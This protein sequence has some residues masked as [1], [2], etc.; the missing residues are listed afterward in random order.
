MIRLRMVSR[1][2]ANVCL[3]RIFFAYVFLLFA[4]GFVSCVTLAEETDVVIV[5]DTE[6]NID[7][8]RAKG[9]LVAI[10]MDS[11]FELIIQ[12]TGRGIPQDVLS[13]I[14]E[15]FYVSGEIKTGLGL[16]YIRQIIEEH[17]GEIRISSGH[18]EGTTV[19][20]LLPTHI[21]ELLED[22]AGR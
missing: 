13:H 20:I 8:H 1:F 3:P 18:P 4:S 17:R 21:A 14:F 9:D 12:D 7:I 11:C 22:R 10:C 16:P 2:A 5:N 15:P 19:E 6:I